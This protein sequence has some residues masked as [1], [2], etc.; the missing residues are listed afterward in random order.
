VTLWEAD[1]P[2][3]SH[4]SQSAHE[5]LAPYGIRTANQHHLCVER[6]EMRLRIA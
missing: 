5:E 6:S 2:I 3:H 1:E 4:P